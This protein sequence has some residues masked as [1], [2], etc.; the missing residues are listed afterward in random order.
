MKVTVCETHVV[1]W[2]PLPE[3]GLRTSSYHMS[4]FSVRAISG[5]RLE[6]PCS[7][8][9]ASFRSYFFLICSVTSLREPLMQTSSG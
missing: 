4:G 8:A 3:P 9:T 6:P 2:L 1:D 5:H 7:A